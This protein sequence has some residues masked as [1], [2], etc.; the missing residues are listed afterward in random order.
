MANSKSYVN[1]VLVDEAELDRLQQRQLREYSPELA[2][3]S[4]LKSDMDS[5]LRR[6]GLSPQ[7]KLTRLAAVQGRFEKIRKDAC[8]LSSSAS[9]IASPPQMAAASPK[10]E[11]NA[12]EDSDKDEDDE[13]EG[14]QSMRRVTVKKKNKKKQYLTHFRPLQEKCDFWGSK[15]NMNVRREM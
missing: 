9:A 8:V 13:V 1:K 6:Y 4:R 12:G 5:I 7:E 11:T 2:S 15:D 3:L 14:R 10:P